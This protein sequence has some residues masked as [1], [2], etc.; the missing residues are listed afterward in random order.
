METGVL[1]QPLSCTVYYTLACVCNTQKSARRARGAAQRRAAPYVFLRCGVNAVK[2]RR[3]C[4]A[5]KDDPVARI[6]ANSHRRTRR[7]LTVEM[8]YVGRRELTISA[9]ARRYSAVGRPAGKQSTRKRRFCDFTALLYRC[10][11]PLPYGGKKHKATIGGCTVRRTLGRVRWS[12]SSSSGLYTLIFNR[13]NNNNDGDGGGGKAFFAVC[14]ST[15]S[16]CTTVACVCVRVCGEL[17]RLN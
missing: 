6:I 11:V 17:L 8:S 3:R 13:Q 14:Q 16:G 7:N 5:D 9:A 15:T 2:T 4:T 12:R 10:L 1:S